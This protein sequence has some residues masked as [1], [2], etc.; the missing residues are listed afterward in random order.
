[1]KLL[2][3]P[4]GLQAFFCNISVWPIRLHNG[5]HDPHRMSLSIVEY[6]RISSIRITDKAMGSA[7]SMVS[8][9]P[10]LTLQEPVCEVR[11]WT[12]MHSVRVAVKVP[13][14]QTLFD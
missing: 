9:L 13:V 10:N 6:C 3:K 8:N 5:L 1:M 12:W 11:V 2:C 7:P 14:K 4:P